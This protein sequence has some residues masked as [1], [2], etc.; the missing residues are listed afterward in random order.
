MNY[1]LDE[2]E[3]LLKDAMPIFAPPDQLAERSKCTNYVTLVAMLEPT[4]TSFTY[5]C[6]SIQVIFRCWFLFVGLMHQFFC[7][8]H[9]VPQYDKTIT[10]TGEFCLRDMYVFCTQTTHS[11]FYIK[12]ISSSAF[13]CK[14]S[15]THLFYVHSS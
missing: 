14:V 8:A 2:W 10:Q 12:I 5:E 9:S 13:V 11:S 6:I 7:N 15:Y 3:W 1:S 4:I